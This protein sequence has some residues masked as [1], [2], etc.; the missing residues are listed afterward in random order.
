M[1]HFSVQ[2][3]LVGTLVAWLVASLFV[4]FAAR[5]VIDRSSIIASLLSVLIGSLLAGFVQIGAIAM[6]LPGWAVYAL[7]FAA[8]ALVIA[9]FFR[10]NWLKGAIIGVIA[11]LL[12]VLVNWLI[13]RL[14]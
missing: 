11:A 6:E 5:F 8:V 13:A 3:S 1:D 4:Y 12:W 7:S 10:T 2:G 9:I 14:F